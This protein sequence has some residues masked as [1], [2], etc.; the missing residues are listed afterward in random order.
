MQS[1]EE[2]KTHIYHVKQKY[3][4]KY[5]IPSSSYYNTKVINLTNF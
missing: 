4:E 3:S 5:K 2:R 1:Y